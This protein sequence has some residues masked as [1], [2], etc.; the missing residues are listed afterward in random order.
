MKMYT[1]SYW[2]MLL[3][4]FITLLYSCVTNYPNDMIPPPWTPENVEGA[5]AE[6]QFQP[7]DD[8]EVPVYFS[9][10]DVPVIDGEFD[11]WLGLDG[12]LTRLPVFGG[13]HVPEDAEA[14]FVLRTDGASLYVYSRV[15]DDV[16]S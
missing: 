15:S 16:A 8:V 7:S 14:F 9:E 11:E 2:P 10:A 3:I 1:Y 13:S 4:S 5:D 6:N 12:P